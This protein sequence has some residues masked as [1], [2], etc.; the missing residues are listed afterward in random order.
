MTR[1]F[2][3]YSIPFFLLFSAFSLFEPWVYRTFLAS[4]SIDRLYGKKFDVIAHKGASGLAPENTMSSFKKAI[5]LGSDLIEIDVRHTADEEIVVFH[6]QR[7]DRVA[8]DAQGKKITGDLHNYTLEQVKQFDVGS[9]F[10]PKYSNERIPT[11]KETLDFINGKCKVLIE[12]KHMDHPHYEDFS[13]KLVEIIHKEKNGYDWII[14]QSYENEYLEKIHDLDS[15][16]KTRALLLGEDSTPLIGFYAETRIHLGHGKDKKKPSA[17]NPEWTSLSP[18]RVFR[19][20]AKGYKVYPYAVNTRNDIIKMLNAGV[21]G[22]I[23]DYPDIAI[24]LKKE[25]EQSKLA[26]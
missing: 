10:D 26:K 24:E 19:M 2:I 14:L 25:T 15:L 1:K 12:I 17:L 16:I 3:I 6:D 23:T 11:L 7:I 5:E 21:D 13:E 9:W 4:T 8:R 22:I 18:R 20:H